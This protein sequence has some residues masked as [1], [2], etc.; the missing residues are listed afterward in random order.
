MAFRKP[1]SVTAERLAALLELDPST[2]TGWRWRTRPLSEFDG[3]ERTFAVWNT[4]Y[5][6]KPAGS[7]HQNTGRLVLSL[8][9]KHYDP[10][11]LIDELGEAVAAIA[12]APSG[13]PPDGVSNGD[14]VGSGVLA[15]VIRDAARATGLSRDNLTVMSR[16]R[17]PYRLDTP[18]GHRLGRWFAEHF[19][20]LSPTARIH[21][22]GFHY[23]LVA[24][25]DVVKPDGV[26]YANTDDDFEWLSEEAAKAARWL[27]YVEF[28]RIRDQR[29]DDPRSYRRVRP[30]MSIPGTAVSSIVFIG[31]RGGGFD[32][33]IGTPVVSVTLGDEVSVS[34]AACEPF[35]ILWGLDAEQPYCFALFGEKSSLE[36]VLEP[37]ARQYGANVYLCSGEI[38]DTLIYH[39]ASDA[40]TDGRPLVVFTFSD[41]DPAGRQMPV[42]IGR[43]LQALRDLQFP[44]LSAEVVPVSLTLDQVID[45]RLP[46]TPVKLGDNRRN[47]WDDAFGAALRAAGLATGGEPAQVEIDALAAIRPEELRRIAREKIALYRDETIGR[48]VQAAEAQWRGTAQAFLAPQIEA[49]QSRLDEIKHAAEET[50]DQF[51]DAR[52]DL[53]SAVE[54]ARVEFEKAIEEAR[55]AFEAAISKSKEDLVGARDRM[56]EIERDLQAVMEEIQPPEPPEQLRA[57]ID[58]DQQAPIIRLDWSFEDATAALKAHKAYGAEEGDDD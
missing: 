25:G 12:S 40:D 15:S 56:F 52:N 36:P 50:V 37:I 16:G 19:S 21:L 35:P 51:N 24:R 14:E 7:R 38:S 6:G 23:V 48:R 30:V 44:N 47:R 41:F 2:E 28:D 42:S 53:T 58:V 32:V 55:V 31:D 27:G 46:T 45:L 49:R 26:R 17:D 3:D 29:N 4:K 10:H 1:L 57:E 8:D 39:M 33:V 9:G 54:E 43:K 5:G 11:R 18:R 34:S 13:S 22:R 20:Q